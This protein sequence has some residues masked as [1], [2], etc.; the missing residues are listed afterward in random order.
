MAHRESSGT[1]DYHYGE[2][3]VYAPLGNDHTGIREGSLGNRSSGFVSG[4]MYGQ[5]NYNGGYE[6]GV[7]YS[8]MYDY[9]NSGAGYVA[10]SSNYN[11]N[12]ARRSYNTDAGSYVGSSQYDQYGGYGG[13]FWK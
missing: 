12:Q 8:N 9:G 7:L 4:N 2:Q 1:Q 5:R 3:Q 11:Y 13:Q 6:S 10:A